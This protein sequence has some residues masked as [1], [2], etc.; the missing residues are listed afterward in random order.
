MTVFDA[1][2]LVD[3][4]IVSGPPGDHARSALRDV[5]VLYVPSIFAA[6]ATSAVRAMHRR[7]DVDLAQARGAVARIQHVTTVRYPFE[8]FIDRVW[9]LRD[10]LSVYDAWYVALAESLSTTLVTAD[11]RLA[12]A[13]APGG[14]VVTVQRFAGSD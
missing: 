7:G 11:E 4:L 14:P 5:P 12:R 13:S 9:A 2:V 10:S 8:P 1:S 6:E 3:A